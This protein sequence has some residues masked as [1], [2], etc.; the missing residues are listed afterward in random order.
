MAERSSGPG[1]GKGNEWLRVVRPQRD[2][3]SLLDE[4]YLL[5]CID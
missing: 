1:D 2:R 3:T 4:Q 5:T